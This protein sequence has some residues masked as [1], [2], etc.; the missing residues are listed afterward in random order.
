MVVHK[1]VVWFR[2]ECDGI[3]SCH[4][5]FSPKFLRVAVK[6]VERERSER[7]VSEIFK[8]NMTRS[9]ASLDLR[10]PAPKMKAGC[11]NPKKAS[12]VI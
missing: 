7:N 8:T 4:V 9:I 5:F 2:Q 11:C 3:G 10:K 1:N 6:D 12:E